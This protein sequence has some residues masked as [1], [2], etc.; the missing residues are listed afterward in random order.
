MSC[1]LM[2]WLVTIFVTPAVSVEKVASRVWESIETA[3]S[4]SSNQTDDNFKIK[5][6]QLIKLKFILGP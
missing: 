3:Q 4:T 1:N 5:L 6:K 2:G